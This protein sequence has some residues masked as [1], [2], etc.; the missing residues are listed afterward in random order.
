MRF[1]FKPIFSGLIIGTFLFFV[2]FVFPFLFFFL[3]FFLVARLFRPRGWRGGY[4]RHQFRNDI[5]PIDGYAPAPHNS[6]EPE[7]K[8]NIQ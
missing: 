4:W 5:M 7:R 1:P 6:N 2:P 8:I 3:F